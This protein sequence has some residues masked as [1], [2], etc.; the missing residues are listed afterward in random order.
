MVH[1]EWACVPRL[2][3]AKG[4]MR[5][6]TGIIVAA[7]AAALAGSAIA[8]AATDGG[9]HA[10][11]RVREVAVRELA[12]LPYHGGAGAG[13]WCLSEV[14]KGS[15]DGGYE[16]CSVGAVRDALFQGPVIAESRM[17]LVKPP[18]APFSQA[19]V[20]V[21]PQVA[22]V[23]VPGYRRIATQ[24]SSLLPDHL[25]GAI[26][27]LRG[28]VGE[29]P[30]SFPSAHLVAWGSSGKPIAQS[31]VHA[32][33][34]AFE[35]PSREWS[36]GE[37]APRGVCSLSVSG[38]DEASFQEGSVMSAV[39]PHLDVRGREFID[40]A[41]STYLLGKWPVQMEANV[42]LDAARP[43]TPPA[44]L[45]AVRPFPGHPGI[46]TGPGGTEGSVLV[47][48]IPGAW[49]LVGKG[50]SLSQ[51][52]TLLEHLHATLHIA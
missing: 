12:L 40:C 20:L 39:K 27:Q 50:K 48:R 47:R 2:A 37:R 51:R 13:G 1:R 33:P 11:A 15:E 45:P 18:M 36:H 38:L 29:M 25:R 23:S 5:L 28:R 22:A 9:H 49:L 16:G 8:V 3:G 14:G 6:R 7:C 21:T 35:E 10:R 19:F 41:R 17:G 42:M 4:G 44:P 43:G 32:A 30:P 46:F 24:A 34:L 52:L 31:V 26:V